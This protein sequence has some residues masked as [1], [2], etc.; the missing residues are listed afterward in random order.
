MKANTQRL[1]ISSWWW[2]AIMIVMAA[3]RFIDIRHFPILGVDEGLWNL[4]AKD[5]VLFGDKD[6][7]GLRQVF[8]SP[9]HYAL[10]WSLFHL[11]PATCFSVR[12][13]NGFLGLLTLAMIGWVMVR[14][15]S[16]RAALWGII[17]IGLSFTMVSINRRAYLET[18]VM[19]LSMLAVALSGLTSRRAL[20]GV[21]LTVAALF[22]YKS[23]ATYVLPCLLIP[24]AEEAWRRGFGRRLICVMSGVGLA[25]A[26]MFLVAWTSPDA[27]QGA[28]A[29]ELSKG[30]GVFS[31]VRLGRFGIYPWLSLSTL[32]D[33]LLG[34]TDLCLLTAG[35]LVCF[36][37][38]KPLQQDRFALKALVWLVTGYAMLLCQGFQHLQY[39][40]PLIIPAGLLLLLGRS[41]A[42][43]NSHGFRL[44]QKGIIIVVIVLSLIRIGFG[45]HKGC[46]DNPPLEAL[47]WLESQPLSDRVC[48][49]CPEIAIATTAKAYAFNRIF[50]PY[51]PGK[52]PRL[53]DFVRDANITAIIY[54]QWETDP[55]FSRKSDFKEDLNA[56]TNVFKRNLWQ[57]IATHE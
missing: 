47:A 38:R 37:W 17:V 1:F 34:L 22:L 18:G 5:A 15:G 32:G 31:L 10:T 52:P 53:R 36:A 41:P 45:W 39:F 56:F 43:P 3:V 9:L 27:F 42:S 30:D 7:N 19:C 48:L 6:L 26:G 14:G 46:V 44:L 4:Q 40:A 23:N 33:L 57:G 12:I 8:L 55:Y 20:V 21:A 29:F 51:P 35:G 24:S 16:R 25:A 13:L 2:V 49:T 54:D 50:H 11:A 28:Y